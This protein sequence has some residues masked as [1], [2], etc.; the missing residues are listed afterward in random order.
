MKLLNRC[1]MCL[2]CLNQNKMGKLSEITDRGVEKSI[3][4]SM[5]KSC[6]HCLEVDEKNTQKIK[7]W[8]LEENIYI[9]KANHI[10]LW[11]AEVFLKRLWLLKHVKYSMSEWMFC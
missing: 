11:I 7:Y 9:F 10:V 6:L 1:V 5:S 3:K 2:I 8:D 4:Q